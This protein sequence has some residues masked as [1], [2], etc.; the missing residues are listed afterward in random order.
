MRHRF[1]SLVLTLGLGAFAGCATDSAPA[2]AA[3]GPPCGI[4]DCTADGPDD[5]FADYIEVGGGKADAEGVESE[6]ASAVTD[7]VFDADDV[8]AA[9]DATGNRV[10]RGEILT[11]RDALESTAYE[12]TPEAVETA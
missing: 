1:L 3:D 6:I 12:V 8:R 11:I 2:P 9:F 10:G 4:V 5:D 7:G